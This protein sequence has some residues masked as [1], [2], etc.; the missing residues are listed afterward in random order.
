MTSFLANRYKLLLNLKLVLE[1]IQDTDK[2]IDL[3]YLK[4]KG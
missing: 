3:Q 4:E 2:I 1:R